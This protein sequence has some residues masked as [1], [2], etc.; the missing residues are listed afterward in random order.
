M[1]QRKTID[2]KLVENLEELSKIKLSREEEEKMVD[3]IK[4]LLNYIDDIFSIEVED[5][6]PYLHPVPGNYRDDEEKGWGASGRELLEGAVMER[7]FVV[8]PSVV[9]KDEES[10]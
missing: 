2:R 4:V 9:E 8:A 7:G 10:S 6:E 3:E 5:I 1:M